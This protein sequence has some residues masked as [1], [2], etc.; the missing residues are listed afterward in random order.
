MS[1]STTLNGIEARRI[2]K[3]NAPAMLADAQAMLTFYRDRLMILAAMSPMNVDDGEGSMAW[4]FYIR[5]E[6]DDI[7]DEIID[8][9]RRAWMAQH[10]I[11]N[12][13]DCED[14]YEDPV[15]DHC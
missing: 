3:S 13:E 6:L 9:S 1:D 15:E 10:I 4:D 7:I 14:P 2:F 5:R 11:D 8:E 12:P